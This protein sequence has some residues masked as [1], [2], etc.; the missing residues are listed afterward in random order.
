MPVNLTL[1]RDDAFVTNARPENEAPPLPTGGESLVRTLTGLGVDTYFGIPGG[2]VMPVLDAIVRDAELHLVEPRQETHAAFE[3]AGYH[4]ATGRVPGVVVTAGPGATNVVTGVVSAHLDRVPMI[5]IVGDESAEST[6]RRLVQAVGP[7]GVGLE[8]MLS[9]VSRGV[10]RV[11]NPASIAAVARAACE[12]AT[13]PRNMGPV[14][15]IVPIEHASARGRLPALQTG[16]RT[17]SVSDFPPARDLLATLAGRLRNARRPLV[18]V[19]AGCRDASAAVLALIE[20]MQCPFVTTPQAKGVLPETHP[21]SLRNA[22][23]SSS[24]WARTYCAAGPDFTIALGTDLDD[25]STAGTP[26]IA[27]GGTLVHVT[28]DASVVGRNYETA[29]AISCDLLTFA[30]TFREQ[31]RAHG[32]SPVGHALAVATRNGPAFDVPQFDTDRQEPI[33][34][35]RVIAD[36]EDAAPPDTTFVSDIGEHMLFGLHYLTIGGLRRFVINVGLGSMASGIAASVGVAFGDP[37]R[38][39]VCICGD[40]GMQMAGMEILVAIEHRL[41]IVFAVFNDARYNMVYHGYRITFGR[42]SRWATPRIDFVQWAQALGV[43]GARIERPGQIDRDLLQR[44]TEGRMPA[45]LDIRHDPNI[46][47]GGDG[48]LEAL[49]QMSMGLHPAG[50]GAHG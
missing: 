11:M 19:G 2:P 12:R 8:R 40:G 41:P 14:V 26:P 23:I 25:A 35:H 47:I 34:P 20:S 22:G 33:A 28:R 36:L 16:R 31:V 42:E 44:L 39:V 18:F 37:T 5:V 32:G 50:N 6:G 30:K 13:D 24:I 17:A 15:I 1:V 48:R 3:A 7:D 38:T 46:R 10:F 49:R 27:P 43:R 21:L 4:R 9:G 29:F 45:V